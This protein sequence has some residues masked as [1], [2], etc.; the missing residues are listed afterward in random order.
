MP[1]QER[2]HPFVPFE[3]LRVV[4]RYAAFTDLEALKAASA[5]PLRLSLRVNT[6]KCSVERFLNWAK[7]QQWEVN[8]VP[9][10]PEGLFIERDPSTSSGRFGESPKR[11]AFGKDLLHLL[12]HTYIQEA[13]S[14]LPVELLDPQPGESILDLAAA[15][16]SK[17]T[18]MA[19]KMDNTGVIVANDIQEKRLWALLSNLQRCGVLNTVVTKKNGEWFAGNTTER[20]DRVLV[21]APCTAQGTIRKD[22]SALDYCSEHN[23]ARMAGHQRRLLA[24]GIHAAKVGARIVYSTCTL[25]P[26]ENEGIVVWALGKFQG[27]VEAVDPGSI[28]LGMR[29]QELGKAK[30]DSI[31]L[32]QSLIPH[33]K[34]LIPSLRLWPQTY[35]TE[36][37]FCAVLQKVA[38]TRDARPKGRRRPMPMKGFTPLPPSRATQILNAVEEQYGAIFLRDGEDLLEK[39]DQIA[40]ATE[41]AASLLGSLPSYAIGLPFGKRVRETLRLSH[42]VAIL[43]GHEAVQHTVELSPQEVS[44]ALEGRD[45]PNPHRH[46]GN[47]LLLSEGMCLGRALGKD[48]LLLNRLP[49]RIVQMMGA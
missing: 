6:I 4:D 42:E 28:E 15:P 41:T 37:F 17:T 21:D 49:R 32:Q 23:I 48:D 24:A 45:L 11:V 29:N 35:D 43:R 31:T 44:D 39:N 18:Q 25:T 19:A 46:T 13:A 2:H 7:R 16:G 33:S 38:T 22:T 10:C 9:W 34:F 12:G 47:I 20:F 14:M 26:E 40:I 8:P 30:D 5:K 27:Q 3:K 1:T 36:G